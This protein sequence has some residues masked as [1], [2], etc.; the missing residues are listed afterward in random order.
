MTVQHLLAGCK[1]L[2]GLEYVRRHE[3]ALK[4]LVTAAQAGNIQINSEPLAGLESIP[5]EKLTAAS[6]LTPFGTRYPP[7]SVTGFTV[8]SGRLYDKA[9]CILALSFRTDSRYGNLVPKSGPM[10]GSHPSRKSS[11][12]SRTLSCMAWCWARSARTNEV[13]A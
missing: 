4:V 2:A 10:F 5:Y 9:G 8:F 11:I 13:A 3:N 7:R 1:K 12:S 6:S